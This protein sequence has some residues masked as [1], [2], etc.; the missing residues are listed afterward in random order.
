MHFPQLTLSLPRW[1]ESFLS[2][3]D[4]VY[5][6]V[7]ER[8]NLAI[9]LSR[10]N[11]R[12]GT[13]GPFGAGVFDS[14]TKKLLAPGINLV[15]SSNCS[16]AHAEMVAIMLAQQIVGHFDLGGKGMPA[17]E[18]V[19][20]TEPCAMCLGGIPWSGIRRLV[21]GAREEDARSIG[22]DEGPKPPNWVDVFETLG[23]SVQL[24]ICRKEASSVLR[25]YAENG[26]AIYNGRQG[27]RLA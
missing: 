25:D 1:V 11:V 19:V 7:E 27:E 16:I 6:T 8:M 20:S 26:G 22:F 13:G 14:R 2:D 10:L 17:Y 5:P 15:L 4:R 18:L 24:D 3:P 9:E 21:C 12:Y 23:I